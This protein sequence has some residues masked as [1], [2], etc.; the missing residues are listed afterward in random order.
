MPLI[1]P[2][3]AVVYN[4]KAVKDV[5]KVVAPPYDII[6]P[7][8]QDELYRKDPYNVVRLILGKIKKGDTSKDNRYTRAK[9]AFEAWFRKGII[10]QDDKDAIYIYSQRYRL[11]GKEIDRIGFMSLMELN[12]GGKKTILP[13]ENTL[14]APKQDRLE[15]MKQ[16][17]ANLS[18][19]FLLYDDDAHTL[20]N[21]FKKFCAKNKPF[22]NIKIDGVKQMVWRMDDLELIKKAVAEI[23]NE[24]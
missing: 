8:M 1:K 24:K 5:S 17:K 22:I 14:S 15:L 16:V 21:M 19:I 3:K 6:P 11:G 12:L 18:P 23:E 7:S 10:T 20:V 13:H 9:D 4:K 2:F